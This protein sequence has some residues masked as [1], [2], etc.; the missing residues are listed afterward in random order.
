MAIFHP[1][2]EKR[3]RAVKVRM[4][5][6]ELDFLHRAAERSRMNLSAYIRGLIEDDVWRQKSAHLVRKPSKKRRKMVAWATRSGK[7]GG[8]E[9]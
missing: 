8:A 3:T 9:G 5:D 2:Q 6:A 4:T 1:T 7:G